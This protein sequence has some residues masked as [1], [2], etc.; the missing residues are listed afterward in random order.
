METRNTPKYFKMP[1]LLLFA[2]CISY[3]SFAEDKGMFQFQV[4]TTSHSVSIEA[5]NATNLSSPTVEM[6]IKSASDQRILWEGKPE[7]NL[8]NGKLTIIKQN[9]SPLIWSPT[10]PQ[11]Y[12]LTIVVS[13]KGNMLQKSTLRIGFRDFE[14]RNGQIFLNG[15]PLF[16]RGIA[17]NPPGRGIPDEVETSRKFAEEYVRFMK[18]IHVNIIRI[19][20][21]QTWYDVCDELG[22][23]V[24]GGNYSAMVDGQSPPRDYD[25]A[26]KWYCD[27]KFG[28]IMHHPSLVIYAL[29][30]EVPF[31]GEIAG[32]WVQFLDYAFAK[33]KVWD[34]SRLYIGNAGYGLG[35]SGDICDIHRYWGWYYASPFTFLNIRDYDQIT[36]S[37]KVQPLTF[38]ECVGN[39]TGPDGRYYLTPDHKNRVSQ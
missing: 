8:N 5:N 36:F 31:N 33:L 13:N 15:H 11:L 28:P 27:V 21:D 24:F 19:P 6:Q 23:L 25:N 10:Q 7:V 14:S 30:N 4:T 37:G 16:L 26:V 35:K 22:M 32:K 29:T 34:P 38:T 39:Y 3:S 20:E 17:I 1:L 9:L 18:S 2:V 12:N